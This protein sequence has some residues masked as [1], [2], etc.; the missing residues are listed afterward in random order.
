M[1]HSYEECRVER[2]ENGEMISKHVGNQEEDEAASITANTT[3]KNNKM[4]HSDYL[5]LN[6]TTDQDDE[7]D[8]SM[9]ESLEIDYSKIDPA[10][11]AD[12]LINGGRWTKEEDEKLKVAVTGAGAKNW[13]KI[14]KEFMDGTRTD[15][16]CLHRWNKVLRPG[17]VKGPWTKEEDDTIRDCIA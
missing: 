16:Q 12:D 11:L 6:D 2:D 4:I 5:E 3:I 7:E 9:Y 13:K 14:S 10:L 17:L 8:Y 1:I 15:V